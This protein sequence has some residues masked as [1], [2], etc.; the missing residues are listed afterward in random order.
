[1]SK[2][3]I[4][5]DG[6]KCEVEPGSMV[7]KAADDAGIYIPRFCYHKKLSIAANC[8][9]CLVDVEKVGK[10]LPACATPVQDGMIVHTK[11]EKAREAQQ[12][13]ME[14]LLI[15]H[16]LD[17]PIC[18]QGGQ[19]ELQD[20]AMGYGKGLSRYEE[21]KRSVED[22][23]LGSLISTEMTR[24]IHCT[25]C[26]RFG[27]EI[28]GIPQLGMTGRGENCE[29]TTYIEQ[30]LTSEMSGNVIDLCPVGALTSK[31]FRYS[32]R[33][34]EMEQAPSIAAHDCVGSHVQAHRRN[35]KVM[36]VIP[37]D[38][39]HLNETWLSDRDR[40]SYCGAYSDDRVRQPMVKQGGEW[41]EVDWQTAL[42]LVVSRTQQIIKDNGAQEIGALASASA[43]TEELYLF[44]K[45][46][47][48]L[49]SHNIDHRLQQ[50]DFS[51]QATAAAFPKSEVT[52]ADFENQ[53]TLF[54]VG[55]HLRHEQPIINH[56]VRKAVQKG[57]NVCALNAI[58]YDFNYPLSH[59][60]IAQPKAFVA[61]LMGIAKALL[62]GQDLAKFPDAVTFLAKIEPSETE[63]HIAQQLAAGE[64][65]T[66]VLGALAQNHDTASSILNLAE[67]ITRLADAKLA[68]LTPGA[69][70][71][72]AWLA[73]AVPHRSAAGI[74]VAKPGLDCVRQLYKPLKAFF[75]LDT[76][77]SLD[78]VYSAQAKKAMKQADMV[79]AVTPFIGDAKIYAN[80]ILPS[81][82]VFETAGTFVNAA[83]E[84]QSFQA[85][86]E[87]FEAARPAWKILRVL[88]NLFHLDGFEQNTAFDVRDELKDLVA[89]MS[90]HNEREWQAPTITNHSEYSIQRIEDWPMYRGDNLVRRSEPLQQSGAAVKAAA[91]I[92]TNLAK[93]LSL[94]DAEY[95]TVTQKNQT[96]TLPLIIDDRIAE[97]CAYIP[98]GF[99][100]VVDLSG[101]FSEIS[102]ERG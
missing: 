37:R 43:T 47:R 7:I 71:A 10:P 14:F 5:I 93:D 23:D 81:V 2:V 61:H 82:P 39:D 35:G 36:R 80:V 27:E 79:V 75:L 83:G 33:A 55:S 69:N 72:G 38:N 101:G 86:L 56:R 45:L 58:D 8:R 6:K 100:E 97:N 51:H 34:W 102:I 3:T 52:I 40:F 25:R 59:K 73:G 41:R 30:S 13:M 21:G 54:L 74:A 70:T 87:P 4:E 50:S 78:C 53:Q 88:G 28:A 90:T 49:G 44:Q 95:V 15:N 11:T 17:C 65:A 12:A 16:P 60:I 99:F 85:A 62:A 63:T 24:C 96:A 91:Y 32:A 98:G 68:V 46:M 57:A 9:M 66:V 18:D 67:L 20:L 94:L 89:N 77:P 84:W 1:M 31:P 19:C 76:E 92:P 26:I 22:K 42:Q 29:V 48:S 64:A